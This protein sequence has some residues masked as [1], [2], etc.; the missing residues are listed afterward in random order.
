VYLL[1]ADSRKADAAQAA[2][3]ERA[4]ISVQVLNEVTHVAR[5]KIAMP[6]R[7]IE[8]FLALVRS[9]CAV[10]P[11][12]VESHDLGRKLAE[13]HKLGVYDG[14]IVASA[15]LAG[16]GTLYSEDLQSGRVFDGRL[17][18]VNPFQDAPSL[19]RLSQKGASI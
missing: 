14:M 13:Q 4:V 6:W 8:A 19:W 15:L 11:L 18:V 16:C 5:R 9:L 2:L 17:K 1:S 12:T 10:E 3:Q 7:E